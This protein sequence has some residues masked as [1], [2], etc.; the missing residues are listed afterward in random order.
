MRKGLK[1]AFVVFRPQI[2]GYSL[3]Y[4]IVY[5]TILYYTVLYCTIIYNTMLC[6][7]LL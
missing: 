7:A 5:R 4:A 3:R 1:L 6:R 2:I